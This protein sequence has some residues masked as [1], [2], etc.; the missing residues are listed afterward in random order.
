MCSRFWGALDGKRVTAVEKHGGAAIIEALQEE[1]RNSPSGAFANVAPTE[2]QGVIHMNHMGRRVVS[3]MRWGFPVPDREPVV[4]ARSETL[5]EKQLFA[6]H[7]AEKRCLIPV[8]GYYEW[9]NGRPK[10]PYCIRTKE[11]PIFA[12]GGIWREY[13]GEKQFVVITV[14]ANSLIEPFK[15]RMP[16]LVAPEDFDLWLEGDCNEAIAKI[17]RPY[18]AEKMT[19]Y[20]VTRAMSNP[21][22]KAEDAHQP[23]QTL[24][25]LDDF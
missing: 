23:L 24:F 25:G 9:D 3:R 16:C 12:F 20:P 10:Q 17:C 8:Q 11:A 13:V 14:S 7:V 18:P 2:S 22:Y 4:N 6:R 1:L 21:R 19:M 15:D 5:F